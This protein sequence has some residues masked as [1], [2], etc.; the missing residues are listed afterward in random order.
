VWLW[1]IP[2]KA[3]S[4]GSQ[5]DYANTDAINTSITTEELELEAN[6]GLYLLVSIHD[7]CGD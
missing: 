4:S 5:K 2:R 7:E 1:Q 3:N 6:H